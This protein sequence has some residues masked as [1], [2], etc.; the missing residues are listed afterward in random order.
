MIDAEA[1]GLLKGIPAEFLFSSHVMKESYSVPILDLPVT[2]VSN[3]VK[4]T[5]TIVFLLK[6][7]TL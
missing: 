1:Q 5:M 4:L 2:L 3:Y 6:I 7:T